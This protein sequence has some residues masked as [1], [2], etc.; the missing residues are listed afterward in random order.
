MKQRTIKLYTYQE[1]KDVS[2][3]L[4]GKAI[5]QVRTSDW[6]VE[7]VLRKYLS[8][9]INKVCNSE[10]LFHQTP[11]I[12]HSISIGIDF[13]PEKIEVTSVTAPLVWV[14]MKKSYNR[15]AMKYLSEDGKISEDRLILDKGA[16][17][18]FVRSSAYKFSLVFENNHPKL[19]I[20]DLELK[21]LSSK[22]PDAFKMIAGGFEVPKN[23]RTIFGD[24]IESDPN[25]E[26]IEIKHSDGSESII[27]SD[28]KYR[29][30]QISEWIKWLE[31]FFVKRLKDFVEDLNLVLN[32]SAYLVYS[33]KFVE[34]FCQLNEI[35]FSDKG[36]VIEF[37]FTTNNNI[38]TEEKIEIIP[39]DDECKT[40]GNSSQCNCTSENTPRDVSETS[41]A[42]NYLHRK[43]NGFNQKFEETRRQ[44]SKIAQD[45]SF[46]PAA[47][48]KSEEENKK[49]LE[50]LKTE[51]LK[52]TTNLI[53]DK[54][55]DA[56]I[57]SIEEEEDEE[58]E[59]IDEEEWE[60]EEESE[61]KETIEEGI[62][63]KKDSKKKRGRP[64]KNK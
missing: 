62:K 58:L 32:H 41:Q 64:K 39:S 10:I 43:V 12:E 18:R 16:L 48:Q 27:L 51:V 11:K 63:E 53:E 6:F 21:R 59:E 52:K 5:Q 36:E 50:L 19:K 4:A 1:L 45:I 30:E 54:M 15:W 31:E 26:T 8:E 34:E 56:V 57:K 35:Y 46:L 14:N 44:L 24:G 49:R 9:S 20:E 28:K 37:D 61:S 23:N 60:N 55:K 3:G 40:Y 42:I 13:F 47:I 7:A 22:N 38:K 29:A 25:I 2:Q 17:D 33:D